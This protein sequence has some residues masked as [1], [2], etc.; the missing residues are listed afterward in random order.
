MKVDFSTDDVITPREVSY[1]FKLLFEERSISVLAYN[2]ETV[3]A[4][5]MQTVV[6]RGIANT[7]MRDF[8]DIYALMNMS[9]HCVDNNTLRRAFINTSVKRGTMTDALTLSQTVET[10]KDNSRMQSLWSTYRRKYAY[11]EHIEWERAI[12]SVKLLTSLLSE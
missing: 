4:E 1:T 10:V 6:A 3:L 9:S 8:Y 5:K 11:A 2:I 12:D 7:R